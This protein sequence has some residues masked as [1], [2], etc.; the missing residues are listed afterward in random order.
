[1]VQQST[2]VPRALEEK[3]QSLWLEGRQSTGSGRGHI[4]DL[5]FKM[6]CSDCRH[7]KVPEQKWWLLEQAVF[8]VRVA[9]S[10][11]SRKVFKRLPR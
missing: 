8:G 10:R 1:M 3:R 9:R 4:S 7:W 5:C 11:Q 6:V 2:R